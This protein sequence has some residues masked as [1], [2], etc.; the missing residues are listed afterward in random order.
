MAKCADAEQAVEL[1]PMLAQRL[2][3]RIQQFGYGSIFSAPP[4]LVNAWITTREQRGQSSV[5]E[6]I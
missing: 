4:D 3:V 1:D 2:G 6:C 5:A